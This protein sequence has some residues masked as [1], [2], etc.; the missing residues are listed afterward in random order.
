M[1]AVLQSSV[2][3]KVT[4]PPGNTAFGGLT[5]SKCCLCARHQAGLFAYLSHLILSTMGLSH[6]PKLPE[7][8]DARAGS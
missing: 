8:A 7:P 6:L 5:L 3:K 4:S 2:R 1:R